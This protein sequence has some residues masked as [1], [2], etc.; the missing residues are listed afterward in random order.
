MSDIFRIC[1]ANNNM[2]KS[3][4]EK[5]MAVYSFVCEMNVRHIPILEVPGILD[6][7]FDPVNR[8]GV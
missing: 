6:H 5:R 4:Q 1:F 3:V 2:S 8:Y 7:L